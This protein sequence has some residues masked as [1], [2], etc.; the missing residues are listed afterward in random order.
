LANNWENGN[1]LA[2]PCKKLMMQDGNIYSQALMKFGLTSLQATIYTT[3]VDLGNAGILK[4]S[5]ASKIA[6]PE[7]YRVIPSLEEKGLVEKILSNP[8]KYKAVPLKL[9]LSTLLQQKTQE[10]TELLEETKA[11]L[12]HIPEKT[13]NHRDKDDSQFIIT[14]EFKLFSKRL[15]KSISD[16]KSSIDFV[17]PQRVLY[18]HAQQFKKA[19]ERGVKI[20]VVLTMVDKSQ[21]VQ[22]TVGNLNKNLFFQLKYTPEQVVCM[23]ISD[24]NELN[25]Q[26][27][28][29]AVPSL[30]SNNKQV[31][32]IATTYF[33]ALWDKAQD[34]LEMSE[35]NKR[36]EQTIKV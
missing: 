13:A 12:S 25:T 22:E 28:D 1:K 35:N 23:L 5:R 6:R 11:L 30:L 26:I 17:M 3:L 27:S 32:K 15:N 7:V 10:N 31:V 18:E 34:Y 29:G 14:S 19:M 36:L 21:L 2:N 24:N 20:R 33:E 4:I 9:G 16:T 8:T